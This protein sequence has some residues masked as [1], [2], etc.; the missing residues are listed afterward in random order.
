MSPSLAYLIISSPA[1]AGVRPPFSDGNAD[2]DGDE[3]DEDQAEAAQIVLYA[4]GSP[5]LPMPS[6]DT[7]LRHLGLAQGLDHFAR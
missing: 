4:Q 3:W 1:L 7:M 5:G 6:R 2:A